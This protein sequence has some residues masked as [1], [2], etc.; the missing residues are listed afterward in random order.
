MAS[1]NPHINFSGNA[2]AAFIF[3]KS[4][5]GGEFVKFLRFKDLAS[6]ELTTVTA[7]Q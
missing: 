5:F 1:I 6:S 2:E 4:V 7:K 3:Y